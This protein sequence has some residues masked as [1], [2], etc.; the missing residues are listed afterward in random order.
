MIIILPFILGIMAVVMLIAFGAFSLGLAAITAAAKAATGSTSRRTLKAVI[1]FGGVIG[2]GYVWLALG[3]IA[4]ER[5]F[6][7]AFSLLLKLSIAMIGASMVVSC[8]AGFLRG[9][10]WLGSLTAPPARTVSPTLAV[11]LGLVTGLILVIAIERAFIGDNYALHTTACFD[12]ALFQYDWVIW[13][14]PEFLW[15]LDH[16]EP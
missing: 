5:G 7:Y 10:V 15:C 2:F 8:I 11:W 1:I 16:W 6:E 3:S 9:A 4:H 12:Y 13:S 14:T